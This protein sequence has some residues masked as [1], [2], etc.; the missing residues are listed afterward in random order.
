MNE[1]CRG[2]SVL[3]LI[4]VTVSCTTKNNT[5]D[6][7]VGNVVVKGTVELED[8]CSR[9]ISL[10]YSCSNDRCDS[11]TEIIDSN[12]NFRFEFEVLHSQDVLLKYENGF[13]RLFVQPSDS[14]VLIISPANYKNEQYP[15][16]KIT[17][18][19][20]I[21][22]TD[23]LKYLNYRE[24]NEFQASVKNRTLKEYL[25]DLKRQI[26][27]EDSVLLA[28]NKTY[29]PSPTF[30]IWAEKNIRYQYANYLL[31]FKWFHE[32]NKSTYDG[33]LFD[34]GLFPVNDDDAII[35][36]LY[37]YHLKHYSSKY[38]HKD[39]LVKML[40]DEDNYLNAYRI[41]LTNIIKN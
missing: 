27:I 33:E 34:K 32:L 26:A 24:I 28:F 38:F 25:K 12:G 19:N 29:N 13:T 2:L 4:I 20:S 35:T 41:A 17:G 10:L 1:I 16:Y 3:L 18:T 31:E 5:T 23:I 11:G 22:S 30:L 15:E 36:S 7:K 14:L 21:I 39:T 6:I 40:L 37:D 9:V 8:S